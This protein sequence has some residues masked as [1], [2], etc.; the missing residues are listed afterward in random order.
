MIKLITINVTWEQKSL[1]YKNL[2][3]ANRIELNG[4]VPIVT[5]PGTTF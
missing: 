2:R 3:K 4:I 5:F 1:I